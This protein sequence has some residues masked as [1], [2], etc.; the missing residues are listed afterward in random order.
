[1]TQPLS[2]KTALTRTL[3]SSH[4]TAVST[5]SLGNR[6]HPIFPHSSLHANRTHQ[7][8]TH[9][10]GDLLPLSHDICTHDRMSHQR[11]I[12][13]PSKDS[14]YEI[15]RRASMKEQPLSAC[16]FRAQGFKGQEH[17]TPRALALCVSSPINIAPT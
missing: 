7:K 10:S 3:L 14:C 5:I 13:H 1:M 6:Y 2:L 17:V 16:I 12:E 8:Q 11:E 9:K 4:W 15:S